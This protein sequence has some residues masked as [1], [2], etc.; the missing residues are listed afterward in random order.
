[1][2]HADVLELIDLAAVE[3]DGLARLTAG[4]TP[5][6]AAVGGHLAACEACSAELAATARSATLAREAV[7]ELPDPA[8]RDRTL[9]FVRELGRDRSA[10]ASPAA[11]GAGEGP[12]SPSPAVPENVVPLRRSRRPWWYAASVAA[13]LVAA[14]G[15]FALGGAAQP[16][17]TGD[18]GHTAVAA[19]QTTMHIAEQPDAVSVDLAPA[20]SATS[21]GTVMYSALSG[22]LAVTAAGLPPAPDGSVYAC[23]EQHNGQRRQIGIMYVEHG[24]GAWAGLLAGIAELGPGTVFGISLV[25]AGA[26]DG[27]PVLTSGG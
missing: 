12:S 19:A 27:T 21:K 16:P 7:R 24:D 2:E 26:K 22:E 17:G 9:A 23:W 20:S 13:V 8:L 6:S 11:V 5:E 1:M 3:P 4:D 18:D 14:V 25:P 15:G 10:G